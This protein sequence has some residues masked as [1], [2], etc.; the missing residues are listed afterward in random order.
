MFASYMRP[1]VPYVE[2]SLRESKTFENYLEDH[3]L[4]SYYDN[5]PDKNSLHVTTHNSMGSSEIKTYPQVNV[6]P[7]EN[8]DKELEILL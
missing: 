4:E 2:N 8:P 7:V 1:A 3:Y 5:E 6:S